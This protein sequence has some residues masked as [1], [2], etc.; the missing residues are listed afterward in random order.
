MALLAG[1]FVMLLYMLQ[2]MIGVSVMYLHQGRVNFAEELFR[3]W[4]I[5]VLYALFSIVGWI[6][7]GIPAVLLLPVA[8]ISQ[9][10]YPVC[11]LVGAALGPTALLLILFILGSGKLRVENTGSLWPLAILVSTVSFVVYSALLRRLIRKTAK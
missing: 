10:P 6:L 7:V 5:F 4:N 8:R 2:N 9:W 3:T 11:V 1:T